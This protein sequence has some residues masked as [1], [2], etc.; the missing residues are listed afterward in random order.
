VR[1]AVLGSSML[2]SDGERFYRPK[3]EPRR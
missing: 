2:E 1:R 3:P